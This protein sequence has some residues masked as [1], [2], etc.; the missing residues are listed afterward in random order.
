[1]VGGPLILLQRTGSLFLSKEETVITGQY[2]E[3]NNSLFLL[4]RKESFPETL[5][6]GKS[7]AQSWDSKNTA[8]PLIQ[9]S[10]AACTESDCTYY[11]SIPQWSA[12]CKKREGHNFHVQKRFCRF[13]SW[14]SIIKTGN[15]S[16]LWGYL[17]WC[18]KSRHL[19]HS[20]SPSVFTPM[21]DWLSPPFSLPF[22]PPGAEYIY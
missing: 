7:K 10:F 8:M 15:P 5:F 17:K 21:Q 14:F 16:C 4:F 12:S 18:N 13:L 22:P 11:T 9:H 20:V 2:E 1:M 19:F 6:E 3:L